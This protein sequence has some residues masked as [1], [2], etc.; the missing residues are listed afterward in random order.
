VARRVIDTNI[1]SYLLKGHSLALLY[2]SDLQANTV[3]LSFMSVAELREW[4]LKA[5]WAQRRNNQLD[6][7]IGDCVVLESSVALCNWW[8]FVRAS[9]SRQPISVADAWIAATALHERCPLMTHNPRDFR[10]VP[11]LKVITKANS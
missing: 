4:G 8:A 5:K 2:E 10:G 3:I 6:A 9:R 11:G 7:F 1:A